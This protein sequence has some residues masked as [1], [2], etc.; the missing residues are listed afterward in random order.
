M[1]GAI[2]CGTLRQSVFEHV[3]RRKQL[4]V[5][6]QWLWKALRGV[7]GLRVFMFLNVLLGFTLLMCVLRV[8]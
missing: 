5:L 4:L 2:L 7:Y 8:F 3:M 1:R 6:G